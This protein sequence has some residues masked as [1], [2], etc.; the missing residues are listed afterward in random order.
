VQ[1]IK[2]LKRMPTNNITSAMA[3]MTET[4]THSVLRLSSSS[5]HSGGQIEQHAFHS[6]IIL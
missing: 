4:S 6:Q 3:L 1:K 2:L 5:P